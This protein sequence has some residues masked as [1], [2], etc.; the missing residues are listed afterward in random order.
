MLKVPYSY[1]VAKAGLL[2]IKSS[3]VE[4]RP[5]KKFPAKFS[6]SWVSLLPACAS[7]AAV[8]ECTKG[9][10]LKVYAIATWKPHKALTTESLAWHTLPRGLEGKTIKRQPSG[11]LW[12]Q[13]HDL[14]LAPGTYVGELGTRAGRAAAAIT[15][16]AT[17]SAGSD[18]EGRHVREK[19][20]THKYI[21]LT[22]QQLDLGHLV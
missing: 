9:H 5:S 17:S 1:A 19:I 2:F 12:R 21:T 18:E 7:R 13:S 10:W 20:T 22:P 16:C 4:A 8:Q 6:I 14:W 15:G 3:Y 11:R